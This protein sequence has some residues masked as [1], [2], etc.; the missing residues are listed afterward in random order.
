M[1]AKN[2]MDETRSPYDKNRYVGNFLFFRKA[3]REKN[4][5]PVG[6]YLWP[7]RGYND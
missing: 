6:L 5:L 1:P 7:R 2:T 4:N 3:D